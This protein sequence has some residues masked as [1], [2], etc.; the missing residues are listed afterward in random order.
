[1]ACSSSYATAWLSLLHMLVL[2]YM[3]VCFW[4]PQ[5]AQHCI[6]LTVPN[7]HM[8]IINLKGNC[9]R[10]KQQDREL[11]VDVAVLF[12]LNPGGIYTEAHC[13]TAAAAAADP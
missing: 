4:K 2:L 3:L 1:M 9:N 12:G 5:I 8:Y 6:R 7:R 13:Y 10:Q 11:F